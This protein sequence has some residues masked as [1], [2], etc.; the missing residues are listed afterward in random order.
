MDDTIFAL[1]SGRPPGG[2]AVIRVSGRRSFSVGEAIAG[3]LPPPRQASLRAFRDP[4]SG[5]LIDRGLILASPA[6]ATATGENIVEFQ[7]HGGKATVAAMLSLLGR[8][9]GLREAEPGEF[10]RRALAHGRIDLTEA[11]GLADLLSAETELQRRV[12]L[13]RTEGAVR[14]A[15][16]EIRSRLLV[17]AA[18]V[19][20]AIDYVDE[21][22]GEAPP[23][24]DP[25]FEEVLK[26]IDILLQ[27]PP[28]ERLRDGIRVVV[29]G[30]PNAGK[31]SL[32]NALVREERAIV[33]P[34]AG[35]T[36]DV[37]E[38]PLA[39]AGL[40]LVL[41]DTAGIRDSVD[42]VESIGVARARSELNAADILLWLGDKTEAP[43]GAVLVASKCD[44]D[45]D[46]PGLAV[47]AVTGAGLDDLWK[48][49]VSR[50]K[51][52]LPGEDA[53]ALT[54]R[55]RRGLE[56][57]TTLLQDARAAQRIEV[58][59]DRVRAAREAVDLISG[60]AGVEEMLDELF[61]RFCVG[62]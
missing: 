12:A 32:V 9:D 62:K 57:V 61:G 55:E 45:S 17:L 19:E 15:I 30:P 23:S 2:I 18:Q 56:S 16:R 39:F 7:C 14:G 38:V 31:S 27:A 34:L 43:D 1:S 51:S 46:R 11:E 28:I 22:D 5:D 50:A 33:T 53:L 48:L 58:T 26:R 24:L 3:K 6:P 8:S 60:H 25:D 59:A 20:L 37:I 36:R 13:R 10:T 52:A 4:Q 47:S 35:T 44:V 21:E 54:E 49:I 42:P 29:S 41:V 40:P